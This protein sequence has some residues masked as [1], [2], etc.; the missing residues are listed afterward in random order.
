M[1]LFSAIFALVALLPT[2]AISAPS[3]EFKTVTEHD[4]PKNPNSYIVKL[5]SDVVKDNHL[6]WLDSNHK[7][8][9]NVTYRNWQSRV[10]HGYAGEQ[11]R[12]RVAK[13]LYISDSF[14]TTFR[15]T[16]HRYIR[17]RRPRRPSR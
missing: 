17:H 2:F 14:S 3:I 15:V 1:R 8:T 7:S 16:S 4:S 11:C 12:V 9:S 5:K 10:F 6:A 13:A